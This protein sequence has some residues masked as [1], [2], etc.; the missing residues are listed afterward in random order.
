MKGWKGGMGEVFSRKG[1]KERKR[2]GEEGSGKREE[3]GCR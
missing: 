1:R 3:R 2:N